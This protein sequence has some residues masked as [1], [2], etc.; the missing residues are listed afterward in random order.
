MGVRKRLFIVSILSFSLGILAGCN[1]DSYT[2]KFAPEK[3]REY[4]V[5]YNTK[6]Q[7]KDEAINIKNNFDINLKCTDIK[8]KKA[9]IDLS[10]ND[11]VIDTKE[12]GILIKA[13]ENSEIF[14]ESI[15]KIK[16]DIFK[17]SI[18]AEADSFQ[19]NLISGDEDVLRDGTLKIENQQEKIFEAISCFVGEKVRNNGKINMNFNKMLGR[20][21]CKEIG[22]NN[23]SIKGKVMAIKDDIALVEVC[24]KGNSNIKIEISAQLNVNTGMVR[25]M[26]IDIENNSKETG[27]KTFAADIFIE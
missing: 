5:Q 16:S 14:G 23:T 2:I 12:D 8:E 21:T 13:D 24:S 15:H 20:E 17:G 22:L 4:R 27:R 19:Y 7:S 26:K 18:Y 9:Y 11:Y 3:G 6:L 10:Y 25:Y 1:K